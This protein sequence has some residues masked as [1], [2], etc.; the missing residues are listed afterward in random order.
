[1]SAVSGPLLLAITQKK[2]HGASAVAAAICGVLT[3]LIIYVPKLEGSVYLCVAYGCV[4]SIIVA[5]IANAFL[6]KG[7]SSKIVSLRS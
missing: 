2:V 6:A 5:F 4:A 7:N 3:Y 1:M